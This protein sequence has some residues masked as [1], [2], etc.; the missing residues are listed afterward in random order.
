MSNPKRRR[1]KHIEVELINLLQNAIG[2]NNADKLTKGNDF[3]SGG[4]L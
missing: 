1:R 3:K 4:Y 2:L